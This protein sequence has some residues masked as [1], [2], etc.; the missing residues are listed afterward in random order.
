LSLVIAAL[1]VAQI[2]AL[3]VLVRR[4]A[5]GRTRRPPVEPV[6]AG[7]EGTTV[8]VVVAT[9]NEARRIPPCLEGLHAQ[10]LP[11]VEVIVVDSRSSDGTA[12]LVE[13]MRARDERFRVA[14]DPPL[15]PEWIGK[16]WALQHGLQLARGEWVLGIDADTEPR[17]GMVAGAVR[18]A[19]ESRYDMVSFSPQFAGQTFAEQWLQPAMLLT[20]VYRFGAA[21]AEDPPPDRLMANGQCFLARRDLLLQHGGYAVARRSFCDDVTVARHYARLGARV[22]FMDG[23]R[24]YLV[25]SYES[26]GQMWREWGRSLD[27]KDASTPGRQW[28]DVAHLLLAQGAPAIVLGAFALGAL[29][30]STGWG[31]VLLWTN[32]ALTLIRVLMLAALAPSYAQRRLSFWLSPLADPLAAYRVLR[33][34]IR[35]PTTWRGRRYAPGNDRGATR[36]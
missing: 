27:L 11:L 25:R 17:P 18:A 36:A 22:G 9:L 20:L 8:S 4:L 3:L 7:I 19:I 29:D 10:G 14:V 31:R 35:R 16:V 5:P 1:A 2:V 34:T 12:E 30:A 21:G 24:L 26:I 13:A 28:A 32:L 6:E 33:S 23:S 15:P